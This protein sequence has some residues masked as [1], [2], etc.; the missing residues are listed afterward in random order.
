MGCGC[1][2]RREAII[3]AAVAVKAGDMET[4][5][6]EAAFVAT[7]AAQDAR[8]A[9]EQAVGKAGAMLALRRR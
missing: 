2:Q 1:A 3:R 6:K 8:A 9:T 5:A 7:S 4:V